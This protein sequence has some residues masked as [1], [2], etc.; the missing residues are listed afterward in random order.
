M[1]E[2]NFRT[3]HLLW[4]GPHDLRTPALSLLRKVDVRL[5]GKGNSNSHGARPVHLII[6]MIKWIRTSRLLINNSLPCS[7]I[8]RGWGLVISVWG[9]KLTGERFPAV[10]PATSRGKRRCSRSWAPPSSLCLSLSLALSLAL[11]LSLSLSLARSVCLSLSDSGR[12]LCCSLSL[13]FKPHPEHREPPYGCEEEM[14]GRNDGRIQLPIRLW[15]LVTP[16]YRS[17]SQD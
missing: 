11:S 17:C 12:V 2:S 9:A 10:N 7:L 5:P 14:S 1:W 3:G 16:S 15:E 13:P 6:T 4:A 8:L